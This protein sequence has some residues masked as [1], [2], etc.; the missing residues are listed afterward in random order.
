MRDKCGISIP[1]GRMYA[2]HRITRVMHVQKGK[3][4][5]VWNTKRTEISFGLRGNGTASLRKCY[6]SRDPKD[7]QGLANKNEQEITF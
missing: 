6:V 5:L 7:E 1:S 4:K 2:E 3:S